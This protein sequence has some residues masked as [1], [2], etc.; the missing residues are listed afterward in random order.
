LLV[1]GAPLRNRTVDLLLTI[2]S[3]PDAVA[4]WDDAGQVKGGA[5][6][7]RPT[8]LSSSPPSWAAG[9]GD[10]LPRVSDLGADRA[11]VPGWIVAVVSGPG[12]GRPAVLA[13]GSPRGL[14][15]GL[16]YQEARYPNERLDTGG[17][18]IPGAV[19]AVIENVVVLTIIPAAPV[20]QPTPS[21]SALAAFC[22]GSPLGPGPSAPVR[23]G[24]VMRELTGQ[25]LA[26]PAAPPG[27]RCRGP[28]GDGGLLV[29]GVI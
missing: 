17:G 3:R 16:R 18:A 4:N 21:V 29:L 12:I 26:T 1:C 2:Y 8:Y 15:A 23:P 19:S 27:H 5:L 22:A 11:D 14:L 10:R 13:S 20:R 6:C 9:P 24:R 25:I 7:C 28:G